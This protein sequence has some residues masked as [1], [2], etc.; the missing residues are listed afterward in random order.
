MYE[1]SRTYL[2]YRIRTLEIRI[3]TNPILSRDYEIRVRPDD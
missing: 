1:I 2:R 3:F